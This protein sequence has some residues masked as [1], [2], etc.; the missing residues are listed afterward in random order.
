MNEVCY[1]LV[2]KFRQDNTAACLETLSQIVAKVQVQQQVQTAETIEVV[3]LV[4][5]YSDKVERSIT[6]LKAEQKAFKEE[7]VD[8]ISDLAK[9]QSHLKLKQDQIVVKQDLL[10]NTVASANVGVPSGYTSDPMMSPPQSCPSYLSRPIPSPASS[11]CLKP[12]VA[13]RTPSVSIHQSLPAVSIADTSLPESIDQ[14]LD[15]ICSL[16]SSWD[17]EPLNSEL[18]SNFGLIS[19]P[20]EYQ[21]V[22]RPSG[23]TPS[24][25]TPTGATP[26]G[27]DKT[28]NYAHGA[29]AVPIS[30]MQA[31]DDVDRL[32]TVDEVLDGNKNLCTQKNINKLAVKL[33]TD[34]FFGKAVLGRSSLAGKADGTKPLDE[35]KLKM[36]QMVLRTRLYPDMSINNF[37]SSVWPS[38]RQAIGEM[39]KRCRKKTAKKEE[40]LSMLSM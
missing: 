20:T 6:E 7:I 17:M 8:K 37:R 33:A 32:Q 23:A 4:K 38:C 12:R 34:A 16:T 13:T 26:S 31:S 5:E 40:K 10:Q 39:C 30:H 14:F 25:A 3:K 35:N 36:I 18:P 29:S 1:F 21:E 22:P 9:I 27:V 28:S 15:D 2:T 24:G 19:T 11:G